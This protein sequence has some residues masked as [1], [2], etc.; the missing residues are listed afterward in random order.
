[1]VDIDG[2]DTVFAYQGMAGASYSLNERSEIYGGY[3]YFGSDGADLGGGA[4]LDYVS[5]S[6]EV[7]YR[8]R[9]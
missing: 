3:R 7:G 2:E 5:H 4:N 1:M 8:I 6:A 9:F